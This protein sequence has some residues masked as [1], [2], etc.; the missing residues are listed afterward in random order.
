MS[1]SS[2]EPELPSPRWGP[3]TSR[4]APHRMLHICDR[5]PICRSP[6]SSRP[7]VLR[8]LILHV[9]VISW[10]CYSPGSRVQSVPK[11]NGDNGPKN[12][13]EGQDPSHLQRRLCPSGEAVPCWLGSSFRAVTPFLWTPRKAIFSVQN[14]D[15]KNF[16]PPEPG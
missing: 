9:M 5:V 10:G 11:V 13:P 3:L 4:F 16:L 6:S 14:M 15:R 8:A 1:P 12:R 7:P 2:L